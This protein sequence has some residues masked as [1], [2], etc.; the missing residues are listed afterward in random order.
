M[1][2]ARSVVLVAAW[3]LS[4]C[5]GISTAQ[6][7]VRVQ[8]DNRLAKAEAMFA[9]R[10]KKSG[11]FIHRTAE[12]VEGILLM[13]LR[14]SEIN[15]G[16]QFRMNDP[17]GH[18]SGGETYVKIFFAGFYR[19]PSRPP[20]GWVPRLGYHYV[21]VIDTKDLK[22]YR[23]TGSV[24]SVEHTS[25]ILIGGDGKTKFVTKDFVLDKTRATS[26]PPRYG[27][28]YDDIS[29]QE[30]REYWIAGSSLKVLD[31]KTNDVM[32]ERIGYM[33][34]RGQGNTSGG[35]SPWLLA[36]SFACPKFPQD[37]G[38]HSYQTD[39]THDFVVK[40]LKPILEN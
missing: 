25:S 10:C 17:Y 19:T 1:K 38:G 31:L 30:E 2:Q 26:E 22:R 16:D 32:A 21:E 23:Y 37:P 27:V 39:Q 28:T 33:M 14:P 20:I 6:N 29:T 34:D 3:L 7:P 13:K 36:A 8:S 5:G 9:E 4:A 40:V 24:K 11:E 15:Y 18:D 12:S 35:R